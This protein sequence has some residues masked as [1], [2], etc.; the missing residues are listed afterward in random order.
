MTTYLIELSFGP[1]QS[2]ISAARRSRDLWAGSRLLSGCAR[3]AG[4]ALLDGKAKLIY[5]V[6]QRVLQVHAEEDSNL[7][8]VLL[9]RV[10]CDGAQAVATLARKAQDAARAYLL[11]KSTIALR[12]WSRVGVRED[13]WASQVNDALETFAAWCVLDG[14]Y[15]QAYD[16]T[17]DAL[18]ARKNTR[19][20]I[21]MFQTG[22]AL[23]AGVP[24]S[25]L[26]GL[27]ESV[28]PAK[29]KHFPRK[30]GVS[31]GEQLDAMGCIKRVVG[32]AETFTALTRMAADGW[33]QSLP[34]TALETLRAAYEPLVGVDFATRSDGN[35]GCY[36]DFPYDAG[37]LY[38]ERLE[39]AIKQAQET[40]A[41]VEQGAGPLLENLS[42][43]LRPLWKEHGQPCPYAAL[44]VADGDRMG[45][46]VDKATTADQHS[47]V[48]RCIARFAD[49]VPEIA[50]K[51]RGHCIFNGGED[52]MVLFPLADLVNGSRSLAEAFADEMQ[53]VVIQ[54]CTKPN[55]VGQPTLRVGAAI[56]HV[57]EPLGLFRQHGDAA[58][59]FAK[60]EAGVQGQ[61]NALGIQLHVRAGHVVPWRASFANAA[62]F[63]S[64][65]AW[66]D[67]Y[68]AGT[69][70]GKLAYRIRQAWLSGRQS[71]L[72]EEIIALEVQRTLEHASERGGK[73]EISSTLIDAL[74]NRALRWGTENDASG[75]GGLI[76]ELILARWL[77]ARSSQDLGR[78][79]A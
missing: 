56:C 78:E 15:R 20:F 63:T 74:K 18:G 55:P 73:N 59:K 17:K 30:F 58:E 5:P 43:T 7:S 46:F 23:G 76:D 2:F 29:R 66:V 26:D 24:K 11:Q 33:L 65:Q 4:K 39:V 75:F 57:Q 67:A 1:V 61:G 54:L 38:P 19:D 48:S 3:A 70:P 60:G 62:D 47:A 45:S 71:G 32:S 42:K 34:T 8:N 37:L 72:D 12:E 22:T 9:A 64:L 35:G 79:D 52:L 40:D 36:K 51:H 25:S 49:K 13:I 53:K 14:G 6:E 50:R 44:V 77:S 41:E 27:R 69:L 16:R 31:P 10:E 68:A 21:A 28:L